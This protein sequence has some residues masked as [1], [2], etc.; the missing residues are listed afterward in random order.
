MLTVYTTAAGTTSNPTGYTATLH[1]PLKRIFTIAGG[2]VLSAFLFFGLP[3]RRRK[4]KTLLS[5]LLL[6]AIAGAVIGC[7]GKGA[8]AT[9]PNPGTTAGSYTVTVTGVNGAITQ[10]TTV[11]LAVN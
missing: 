11:A 2:S 10:T 5:L 8:P 7:G 4:A 1:N 3:I 6:L 9:P